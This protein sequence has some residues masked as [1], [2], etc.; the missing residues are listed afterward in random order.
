MATSCGHDHPTTDVAFDVGID[1]AY[2][3]QG[4][5]VASRDTTQALNEESA[6]TTATEITMLGSSP[7]TLPMHETIEEIREKHST[8]SPDCPK[9]EVCFGMVR[10]NSTS[11]LR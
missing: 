7:Y 5:C 2:P 6:S 8:H 1:T 4:R 10:A 3:Q 11:L 9:N